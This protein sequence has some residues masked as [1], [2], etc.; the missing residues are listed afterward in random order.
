M[1]PFQPT[2]LSN[3]Q[4]QVQTVLHPQ[5]DQHN[6]TISHETPLNMSRYRKA[7]ASALWLRLALA[8]CHM[9]HGL[10]EAL[11]LIANNLH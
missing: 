8:A 7:V 10:V 6:Q 1:S 5:H 2:T 11:F 4:T 3:H 9:P